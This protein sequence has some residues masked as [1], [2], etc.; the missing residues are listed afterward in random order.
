M[1]VVHVKLLFDA[2]ITHETMEITA[3]AARITADYSGTLQRKKH[4]EI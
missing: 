1:N 3:P 4:G 2:F